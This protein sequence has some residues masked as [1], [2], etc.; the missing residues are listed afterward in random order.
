MAY[1]ANYL[2]DTDPSVIMDVEGA[3]STRQ[4]EPGSLRAMLDRMKGFY[5]IDPKRLIANSAYGS[6]LMLGCLLDRDINPHTPVLDKTGQTD[7]TR[8]RTNFEWH[9]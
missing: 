3:R 2:I 1:F 6:G 8:S 5:D 4:A 9:P 7:D